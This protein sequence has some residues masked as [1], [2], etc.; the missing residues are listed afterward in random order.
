MADNILKARVRHAYKTDAEWANANPIL[1]KGEIAYSSDI[2]QTKTGD[3]TAHWADLEYDVAK[4]AW[5]E[6]DLSEMINKLGTGTATPVNDDYYVSQWAGGGTTNI[7]Y[8]RRPVSALWEYIKAKLHKVATSG[9]YNDLSNKPTTGT[10][11]TSGLTKL[12]TGVGTATDGS[13]TQAAIKTALDGKSSTSHNHD[14]S[15]LKLTGGTVT[16]NTA[17]NKG[18]ASTSVTTGTVTVN[19]GIG[20]TGRAS[21]TEVA[22]ADKVVLKFNSSTNSLDFTFL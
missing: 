17:F 1:L 9:S 11:S 13:M 3:G 7:T 16:G 19:G 4:P 18:T 10:A 22:I 20:V 2:R 21:T 6:H 5:H 15:Y 8:V 12:Y 14:S